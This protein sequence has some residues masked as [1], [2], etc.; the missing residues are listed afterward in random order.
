M[1]T[2]A[3]AMTGE[4]RP[5]LIEDDN[6]SRAWAHVS[7]HVLDNPGTSIVP[8]VLSITGFT[9]EGMPQEDQE[10]RT[11]LDVCLAADTPTKLSIEKVA[12]TIFPQ[13]LWRLAQYDRHRLFDLYKTAFPRYQ[14]LYKIKNRRGL[15]FERLISYGRGPHDGNQLE[16]IITEYGARSGVRASL[17]QASIFDPERDHVRDAQLGFP[18]LQHI[19][20]VQQEGALTLNAF[21][22]TQQLYDKAYGN[23][24]GLCRLG[25][26]MAQEMGFTFSRLNCF[27][28]I[29]KLERIQKSA[30]SLRAVEAAA[31]ACVCPSP[32]L[33]G[34]ER[35]R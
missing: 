34:V 28:G 25:H 1:T 7:L 31:R 13:S 6:L 23:W 17:L 8:L 29:E 5:L 20:F 24:L 10:L 16:W 18:C 19:S 9:P 2:K 3:R 4:S 27:T 15:Y 21:Y 11:A 33:T 26:F 14:E 22:A 32:L 12:W 35:A 30:P